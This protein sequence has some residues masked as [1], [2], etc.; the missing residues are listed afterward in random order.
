MS[1]HCQ[2]RTCP[3]RMYLVSSEAGSLSYLIIIT[4]S[5][6]HSANTPWTHPKAVSLHRSR[7][8]E[9]CSARSHPISV[10]RDFPILSRYILGFTRTRKTASL[11]RRGAAHRC[12]STR[13]RFAVRAGNIARSRDS[14]SI[15]PVREKPFNAM[16]REKSSR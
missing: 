8:F 7:C 9:P 11:Y 12:G 6:L 14:R 2:V 3:V 5:K 13:Y 4:A 15:Q 1:S 10:N 16:R